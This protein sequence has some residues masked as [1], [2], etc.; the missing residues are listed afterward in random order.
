MRRGSLFITDDIT[1]AMIPD[2]AIIT[3]R[4]ITDEGA[5]IRAKAAM[6]EHRLYSLLDD[7]VLCEGL[8]DRLGVL[9]EPRNGKPLPQLQPGDEL[10]IVRPDGLRFARVWAGVDL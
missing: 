4:P 5:S 10:L 3:I 2:T 8:T 6:Q 1:M 7:P 9:I